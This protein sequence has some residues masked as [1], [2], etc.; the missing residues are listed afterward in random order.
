MAILDKA[1]ERKRNT[2]NYKGFD[3]FV[4]VDPESCSGLSFNIPDKDIKLPNTFCTFA[5]FDDLDRFIE[6]GRDWD[7]YLGNG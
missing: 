6:C 2:F 7:I 5:Y 1:S 4:E 3:I